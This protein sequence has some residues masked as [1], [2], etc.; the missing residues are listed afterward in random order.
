MRFSKKQL[1]VIVHCPDS[2][3]TEV[4]RKNLRNIWRQEARECRAEVNVLDAKIQE[5]KEHDD[6]LLFIPCDVECKRKAV[7]VIQ[8]KYILEFQCNQCKGVRI[9]TLS[10]VKYTR[11]PADVSKVQLLSLLFVSSV[12]ILYVDNTM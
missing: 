9:I 7:N 3:D 10:G 6:C 12:F 5:C 1:Q 8:F 2:R 11:N 4:F